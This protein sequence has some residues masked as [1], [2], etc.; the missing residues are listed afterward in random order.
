M[1]LIREV[2]SVKM[3]ELVHESCSFDGR[4]AVACEDEDILNSEDEEDF[5]PRVADP[6]MRSESMRFEELG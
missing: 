4:P 5:R 3:I 1:R 2:R 6:V